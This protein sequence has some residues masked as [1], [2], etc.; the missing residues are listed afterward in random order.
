MDNYISSSLEIK[1]RGLLI[2]NDYYF[3]I[4]LTES[5]TSDNGC[6]LDEP[7]LME[8]SYSSGFNWSPF[9]NADFLAN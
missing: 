4:D 7:E 2:P 1:Q 9:E 6:E 5:Q 3:W 8:S